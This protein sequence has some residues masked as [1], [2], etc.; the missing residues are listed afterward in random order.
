MSDPTQRD[1]TVLEINRMVEIALNSTRNTVGYA[2]ARTPEFEAGAKVAL[3]KMAPLVISMVETLK[4]RLDSTETV[5]EILETD[6]RTVSAV[7][8]K[9][10][11]CA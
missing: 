1:A 9:Y 6:L 7:F 8:S 5:R 4:N 11:P 3:S 2:E 10:A